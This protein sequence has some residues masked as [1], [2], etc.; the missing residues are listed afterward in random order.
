[1]KSTYGQSKAVHR[2]IKLY[3]AKPLGK[4]LIERYGK[5]HVGLMNLDS[6]DYPV[7]P[8]CFVE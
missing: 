2:K 3:G 4:R 8:T 6:C 7:I 1:M 5:Q